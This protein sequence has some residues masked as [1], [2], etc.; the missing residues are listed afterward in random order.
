MKIMTIITISLAM[1]LT[2]R[3]I[4]SMTMMTINYDY[5]GTLHYI[6]REYHK[7]DILNS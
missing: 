6:K 4:I 2:I 5:K 3:V 7:I 1:M